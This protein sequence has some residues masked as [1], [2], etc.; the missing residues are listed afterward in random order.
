M[1]SEIKG[2]VASI[3]TATIDGLPNEEI[4]VQGFRANGDKPGYVF[5]GFPD[6]DMHLSDVEE[7][8]LS[9]ENA[10]ILSEEIRKHAEFASA[11]KGE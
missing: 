1:A 6:G 2:L 9:P 10:H 3:V 7:I 11:E 5:V 4:I 8:E